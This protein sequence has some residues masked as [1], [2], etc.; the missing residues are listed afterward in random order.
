[1]TTS[2]TDPTVADPVADP[3][4]AGPGQDAREDNAAVNGSIVN[5]E[6]AD[7]AANGQPTGYTFTY[8]S[9]QNAQ[10]A[11]GEQFDFATIPEPGVTFEGAEPELASAAAAMEITMQ[12]GSSAPD[13]VEDFSVDPAVATEIELF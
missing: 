13:P 9:N 7:A 8:S 5:G 6:N 4:Q 3:V 10:S 1:M 2:E 11:Q 12:A